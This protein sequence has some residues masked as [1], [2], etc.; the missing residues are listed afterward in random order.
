MADQ[1]KYLRAVIREC[2]DALAEEAARRLSTEVQ[3][4]LLS[5]A[6][7]RSAAAVVLYA[8]KD[9]EVATDL[10]CEDALGSG[11]RVYFPRFDRERGLLDAVRV[12]SRGDLGPG[13]FGI[14]EPPSASEAA[15]PASLAGALICVPGLAFAPDGGRLGRGGGHYDRF[16]AEFAPEAITIGLAYSFQLLDRIPLR[17]FD[18][19]LN[20]IVTESAIHRA[21]D[22]PLPARGAADRG[23][24]PG[25]I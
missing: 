9:N 6:E 10:I 4:R 15:A 14:L 1:K 5:A 22:A 3:R 25:W 24:T 13:A 17:R 19:R 20:I 23:G 8:A 18:R 7:Y 16:L 11:R 2:R 12:E 21:C